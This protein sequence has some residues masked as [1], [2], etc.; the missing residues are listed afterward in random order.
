MPFVEVLDQSRMRWLPL[1]Q[2]SSQRAGGGAVERQQGGQ[3]AEMCLRLLSSD[4]SH[5]YFDEASDG[6]GDG[7]E[8]DALVADRVQR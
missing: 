3:E 2:L 4:G 6:F 8:L 5:W 7:A 1:H